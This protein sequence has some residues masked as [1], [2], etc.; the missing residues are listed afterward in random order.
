MGY[1]A[2]GVS[3]PHTRA[4][5]CTGP[6]QVSNPAARYNCGAPTNERMYVCQM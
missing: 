1:V 2:T 4:D 5:A 3:A 6:T